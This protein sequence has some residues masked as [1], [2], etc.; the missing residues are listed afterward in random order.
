MERYHIYTI[1]LF[2]IPRYFYHSVKRIILNNIERSFLFTLHFTASRSF[3]PENNLYK[4]RGSIYIAGLKSELLRVNRPFT[5]ENNLYKTR[6]ST[7][8]AGL[9]SESLPQGGQPVAWFGI[10]TLLYKSTPSF[11][12]NFS[13][14]T[15]WLIHSNFRYVCNDNVKLET[16]LVPAV[17]DKHTN[18]CMCTTSLYLND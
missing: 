9:K 1:L 3:T 14:L 15:G 13:G 17:N 8:L 12:G 18:T 11:V 5:P 10:L 7:Y 6:G 4:T 16:R 2:D